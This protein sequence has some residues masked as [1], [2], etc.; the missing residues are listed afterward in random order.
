MI[1]QFSPQ[2]RGDVLMVVKRGDVLTINGEDFDFSGLPDNSFLPAEY[3]PCEFVVGR[4][5]RMAGELTVTLL[6]PHG[7]N[8]S[9]AVAFPAP[10]MDVPDGEIAIPRDEAIQEIEDVDG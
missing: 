2:L 9:Q 5:E 4:V 8:P 3:V 7:A 10:I 6:L 1:I